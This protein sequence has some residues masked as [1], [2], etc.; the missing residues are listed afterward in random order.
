MQT[1]PISEASDEQLRAC[2]TLILGIDDDAVRGADRPTLMALISP[3]RPQTWEEGTIKVPDAPP[4]PAQTGQ[5]EAVA[6]KADLT[7]LENLTEVFGPLTR[8]KIISTNMPGG[9]HP[10]H[11]CVNG[12]QIVLQRNMLIDAPYAFYVALINAK[13]GDPY[14]VP[15]EHGKPPTV[16]YAEIT[17]YPLTD[18]VLPPQEAIDE[19]RARTADKL[20]AA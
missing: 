6:P 1:I 13:V 16:A 14:E 8:F 10:A 18:V 17:N 5:V 9:N 3:A 15:G 4:P 2:A 11:P 7:F 20:L 12:K 19:W